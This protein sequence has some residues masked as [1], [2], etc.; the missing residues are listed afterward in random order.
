MRK[1]YTGREIRYWLI[2]HHHNKPLSFSPRKLDMAKKTLA[3]L[4]TF[5][6][7]LHLRPA[8][9]PQPNTDQAVYDLKHKFTEAM[10]DDLNIAKA[11]AALFEF[12]REINRKMDSGSLSHEDR[13]KVLEA[14]KA[15]DD[16]L[17][18]MSLKGAVE[19]H[20][21]EDR[22]RER[23]KA[24]TRK[25]WTA[26]DRIR[27]ELRERG[28]ELTDTKQGTIWRRDRDSNPR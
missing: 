9:L 27:D 6:Q 3:N 18:V 1:G 21:I 19:N 20:E 8:G 13:D 5:V 17:G 25:D 2:S 24:R 15:V 26:A 16:V 4:D 22:I 14:L 12:T 11:L 7:K 10:D 28:I 23:D